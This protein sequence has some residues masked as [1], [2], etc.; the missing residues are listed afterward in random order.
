MPSTILFLFS[1]TRLLPIKPEVLD[2]A[3]EGWYPI[4]HWWFL[5]NDCKMEIFQLFCFPLFSSQHSTVRKS[6]PFFLIYLF[7]MTKD[8]WIFILLKKLLLISLIFLILKLSQIC[9]E[10][11]LS[12]WLL[13]LLTYPIFL[14][15]CLFKY[16]TMLW[17]N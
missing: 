1:Q 9:L 14:F 8:S 7:I 17:H 16:F 12:R 3:C 2:R 15:V 10:S 13:I 11:I 5:P 4:T 6:L